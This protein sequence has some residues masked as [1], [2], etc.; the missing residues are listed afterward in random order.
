MESFEGQYRSEEL[1]HWERTRKRFQLKESQLGENGFGES[2]SK[3]STYL[4]R[5]IRPRRGEGTLRHLAVLTIEVR[6]R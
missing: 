6:L 3:E 1:E 5:L 4:M 2:M